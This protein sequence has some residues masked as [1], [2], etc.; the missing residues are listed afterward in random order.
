MDV[1]RD[2]VEGDREGEER[3]AQALE[4]IKM[5]SGVCFHLLVD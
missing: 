4:A 3:R 2:E 1:E 5:V